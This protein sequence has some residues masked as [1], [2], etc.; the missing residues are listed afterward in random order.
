M[1]DKFKKGLKTLN[2]VL[3]SL[4]FLVLLKYFVGTMTNTRVLIADAMHSLSDLV[5]LLVVYIGIKFASK[6]PDDRFKYGYYKAE[7]IAAFIISLFIIFVGLEIT[8]EGLFEKHEIISNAI[9]AFFVAI[10]SAGFALIISKF[11]K[12]VAK[13]LN[14]QSLDATSDE[15]YADFLSSIGV[16]VAILFDMFGITILDKLVT[17]LL[18]VM[19]TKVGLENLKESIYSLM[20]VSPKD[21]EEDVKKIIQKYVELKDLKLR[22]SGPFIFGDCTIFLDP[23][24]D[25]EKVHEITEKTE[26][27]IYKKFPFIQNIVIHVEPKEKEKLNVLV[28]VEEN[29]KINDHFTKAHYFVIYEWNK[30]VFR[31]LKEYENDC[32]NIKIRASLCMDKYLKDIDVVIAKNMGEIIYSILKSKNIKILK[33]KYD[34]VEK[35]LKDLKSLKEFKKPHKGGDLSSG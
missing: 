30:G 9:I 29:G 21:I 18:G 7:T 3:F 2:I 8:L 4:L 1:K 28:P 14:L 5:A 26:K 6:K 34:D 19:I 10:I 32:K 33:A 11:E 31:K 20:D 35:N 17:I 12:K 16:A 22:K 15:S 25:L 24:L 13:E 23:D 27:I